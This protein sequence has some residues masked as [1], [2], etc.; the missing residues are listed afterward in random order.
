MVVSASKRLAKILQ[1]NW[2]QRLNHELNSKSEKNFQ[3]N[4]VPTYNFLEKTAKSIGRG[5]GGVWVL[6]F[7]PELLFL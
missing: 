4:Q 3:L 7:I 1:I 6:T 2:K 5:G